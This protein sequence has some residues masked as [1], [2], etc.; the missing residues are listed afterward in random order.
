MVSKPF[1]LLYYER[2]NET[3]KKK[4][5]WKATQ[6]PFLFQIYFHSEVYIF[7]ITAYKSYMKDSSILRSPSYVYIYIYEE[8]ETQKKNLKIFCLVFFFFILF[9]SE[10]V[11]CSGYTLDFSPFFDN[12][13]SNWIFNRKKYFFGCL[14][15]CKTFMISLFCA[16]Q[17]YLTFNFYGLVRA[18][19]WMFM[20]SFACYRHSSIFTYMSK[21]GKLCV[22]C[23]TTI[24]L[25]GSKSH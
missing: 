21:P 20:C 24:Q 7:I 4:L 13:I 16:R 9:V 17:E 8:H 12:I 14:K 2:R 3:T 25:D 1:I 11:I 5:N 22:S 23:D 15:P 19:K 10:N 6:K 18:L